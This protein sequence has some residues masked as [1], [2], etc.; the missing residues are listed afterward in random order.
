MKKLTTAIILSLFLLL[1]S[2][3]H[4]L[5]AAP[6]WEFDKAHSRFGFGVKHIFSTIHGYFDNYSGTFLFDPDNLKESK[7]VFEI[8]AKSIQ[9]TIN[10][11]DNHLRSADFFDVKSYPVIMFE[12][13]GIKKVNEKL[14]EV[15]GKLT[16]KDVTQNI[17]LPM[18]FQGVQVHPMEKKKLVAGFDIGL[19]INRLEYKV[20]DGRFYEMG[21]V[22]RDVTIDV[23]LEML[24]NK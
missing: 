12:S 14:F 17:V 2:G 10:K 1:C 7:I 18:M 8:E 21:V 22:D 13:T 6:A 4:A 20:G 23:S 9:T 5:A 16:M 3:F 15:S 24:R 19:T 11:R